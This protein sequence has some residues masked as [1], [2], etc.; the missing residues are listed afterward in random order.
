MASLTETTMTSPTDA[1]L[2]L[3]P[4][5]TLMHCTLRAPELSATSRFVCIWIMTPFSSG[6]LGSGR[7]NNL[8]PL[9]LGQRPTFLDHHGVANLGCVRLVMRG[10]ALR[11]TD[12]LLVDRMHDATLDF[13]DDRLVVLVADH[14]TLEDSPRHV[15]L[16]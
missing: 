14:D 4:P 5:S 3:E 16:S 7:G 15:L 11:T 8:P 2:R 10:I 1:Y 9:R 6:L 12:E 13:D